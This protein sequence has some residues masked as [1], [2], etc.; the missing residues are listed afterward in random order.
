MPATGML[1]NSGIETVAQLEHSRVE[2]MF[3]AEQL[4]AQTGR[5]LAFDRVAPFTTTAFLERNNSGSLRLPSSQNSPERAMPKTPAK[6]ARRNGSMR[7]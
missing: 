1:I 7:R 4:R 3:L 6:M 2:Q 5:V